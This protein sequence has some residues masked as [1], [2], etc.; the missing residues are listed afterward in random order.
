MHDHHN[1]SNTYSV[2]TSLLTDTCLRAYPTLES[3]FCMGCHPD[4]KNFIDN[5]NKKIKLCQSFI[6]IL[7]PTPDPA[8]SSKSIGGTSTVYDNCGFL[9]GD[10]SNPVIIPSKQFANVTNFFEQYQPPFLEG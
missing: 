8:Y 3:Y 2:Y 10:S 6:K 9:T 5:T 7:W 1:A 4:S